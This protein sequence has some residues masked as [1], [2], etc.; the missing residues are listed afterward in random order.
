LHRPQA[1]HA[2]DCTVVTRPWVRLTP[3]II[4]SY[5]FSSVVNAIEG[6]LPP[7]G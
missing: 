1:S 6:A 5:R 3:P 7:M 2:I 4:E